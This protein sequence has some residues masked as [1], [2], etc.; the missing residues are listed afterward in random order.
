MPEAFCGL[1]GCVACPADD[2]EEVFA[3]VLTA[4]YFGEFW[5]K[6]DIREN[7][8]RDIELLKGS[9]ELFSSLLKRVARAS[10]AEDS[11]GLILEKIG[12]DVGADRCYAYRFWEPGRSSMCTNTHEWCADGVEPMISGQ[13]TCDLAALVDF[14]A[15]ITSGRDFLFTDIG[16]IDP[17]SREWL[18]PQ[19]IKSLIAT[20]IVSANN[21]IVGFVGFDFVRK[22]CEEFTDHIV[23]SIHGAAN[24]LLVCNRLHERN[25]AI[26][27]VVG[28][29]DE[30]EENEREFEHALVELQKDA[31]KTH[32][33]HMLDIVLKRMDADLCYVVQI[34]P[35]SSGDVG[36]DNL[37]V[38]G[39]WTNSNRWTIDK[40]LGRVFDARLKTS[41]IVTFRDD[42]FDWIRSN[43]VLEDE[44]PPRLAQLKILHCFGVRIEGR[45]VG[46]LCVGYD[47][48]RSLSKPLADFLR[49]AALVMVT[50]IER[51]STYRDLAVALNIAHLKGDIVEFLF[52]HQDYAEIRD[53]VGSRVCEITGAQHL[54][55][56]SEDGSRGDWFGEDAPACCRNC[57]KISA[58]FEKNLPPDFFAKSE[59]VIVR[60]GDPLPDM[61]LP[62]YCPMKSSVLA[63][64]RSGDG[65]WRMVVDYTNTHSHNMHEVARC[66]RT[67][68]EFLAIA[69]A[70]AR[71]AKTL[72]RMQ[73]HQKFRI[74]TLSYA[75]SKDDLPG[76]IDMMLHRLLELTACDYIAIHSVNGDHRMLSPGEDHGACPVRCESCSLYK[77]LVPFSE[78]G[79]HFIELN[80]VRGQ[81]DASIPPDCPAKSLEVAA[82]YCDGKL[83]GGIALH[84]V[85]RQHKVSDE[86]RCTLRTAAD[87]LSLALERHSAAVRLEAE[88]DRVIEAEKSRS[89]FFSSV[90]HDIRTPLN[91]IIGFSELLEAGGASADESR[92]YLRMILSSGK[93]LLQLINDVLDLSKMDLG[94]MQFS[95][96]PTAVGEIVGEMV[97][98]F[99]SMAKAK[100]Q[101]IVAEVSDPRRFMVDPHRFRQILFNFIG[102]AV[103]YAGPC[104]I[105]I[106]V[107]YE[108]GV[109]TTTVADNG[110]GVPTEKAQ[111]LMQPFVQA[112]AKDRTEGSGLGLAICKRLVEIAHGSISI[113][114][115]PGKG[116]KIQA[117]A[118][119]EVAPE[120]EKGAV[121]AES[122]AAPTASDMPNRILV[123]DDSPVNRAVLKAMLKKLGVADLEFAVD[124]K[125]ALDVL[126]KDQSFDLVMSDMWMPVMDGA[127]LI[128]R[129]RSDGRLAHLKVCSITA[130]VEARTIY[131]DQGFDAL[132]L[133][134]VTIERLTELL[135]SPEFRVGRSN[136]I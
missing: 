40:T 122:P 81:T 66:L 90:S 14:N 68:L 32:P 17:G 19:G 50:T 99:E 136:T 3:I 16:A 111:R 120:G 13:Q 60:E 79:G 56:V 93:T 2:K 33:R 44:L 121:K 104:T 25:M 22:P 53:F 23:F 88:R 4:F 83:W 11:T 84:Y 95:M 103:K 114:T 87:V 128:K 80:D 105:R 67:A 75:L 70:R 108:D 34:H 52:R 55:L 63:Q 77:L 113:D 119:V 46:V 101:T 26:H 135:R 21:E 118:P 7:E 107:A 109:L 132:L 102:N 45:L 94:K 27:D 116:F 112:D 71:D 15:C 10:S 35:D 91:A 38:R 30:Y 125:A 123:V 12:R 49:R 100:G 9:R 51:I 127:E 92:Q 37:L 78:G 64:F 72:R 62:R 97:P 8:N 65:L 39:G 89:Y 110:R 126:E 18:A 47:D 36:P 61:N 131:R 1:A 129:I 5:F 82:V 133:K 73:D 54:I 42:E 130:D 31:S 43:S 6:M 74:D 59:S 58:D 20:P 106:S 86:D 69:Y 134:P 124:G 29:A 57:A 98:M 76:L 96:E 117:R 48:T 115:A 41:S 28:V 85:K 24:L